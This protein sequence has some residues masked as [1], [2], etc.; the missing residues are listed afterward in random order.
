MGRCLSG[1]EESWGPHPQWDAREGLMMGPFLGKRVQP[2]KPPSHLPSSGC[3]RESRGGS[4]K[5]EPWRSTPSQCLGKERFGLE[6]GDTGFN[7]EFWSQ[8]QPFVYSRGG[9]GLR[10]GKED[11]SECVKCLMEGMLGWKMGIDK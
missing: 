8:R 9:L 10:Y 6:R 2:V 1:R 11:F 3:E 7:E 5:G 4:V